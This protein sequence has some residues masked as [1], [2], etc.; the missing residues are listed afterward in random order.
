MKK[1]II[2]VLVILILLAGLVA[3]DAVDTDIL[4]VADDTYDVGSPALQ[5][6]EGHFTGLFIG[7]VPVGPGGGDVF[8]PAAATDDAIARYDGV[9][10]KLIQ[11][12]AVTIN[13]AGLLTAG[14][15]LGGNIVSLGKV[16]ADRLIGDIEG[17]SIDIVQASDLDIALNDTISL[18]FNFEPD[19][20]VLSYSGRCQH[21]TTFET[22]HTTGHCE[23]SITGVDTIG[24]NLNASGIRDSNGAMASIVL[25]N[26]AINT[27]GVFGGFDGADWALFYGVG[28]WTTATHTLLITFST[29]NN[30]NDAQNFIEI[31]ATAYR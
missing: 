7:G 20:I 11:D 21:D 15:I 10:G 13:D 30:C 9:T 27:V 28:T 14:S 19:I 4:P 12:S 1:K 18:S 16:E 31:M 17:Y 26:S 23:I 3:C 2:E 24:Y 6:A 29:V 25:Q 22:G 8:G 5:W